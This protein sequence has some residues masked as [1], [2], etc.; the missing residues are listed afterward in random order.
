MIDANTFFDFPVTH[1][2]FYKKYE[3]WRKSQDKE[4]LIKNGVYFLIAGKPVPRCLGQDME[5]ILYIG[6]GIILNV[7]HRLGKL[8]NSINNTEEIHEAGIRYNKALFKQKYPLEE[9]KLRVIL[10]ANPRQ[11]EKELLGKYI[12]QFGELPPLNHQV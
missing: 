8:I 10:N 3:A 1:T 6:K 5:G 11:L 2:S 9:I 7:R 4:S 12:A